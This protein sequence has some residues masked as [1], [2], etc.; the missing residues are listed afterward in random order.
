M[1]S[2]KL[3]ILKGG[4]LTTVQDCGRKGFQSS[5][6]PVAG[7]MDILS[8]QLANIALGNAP[9]AAC[10]EAT[11]DGPEIVFDDPV[12]LC[13][14]GAN[15]LARLNERPVETGRVVFAN[16]NDVLKMG[17]A[18]TGCRAYIAFSGGIDVP[19]VMGSR[20]TFLAGKTG[21]YHGRALKTGDNLT[22]VKT[23]K[24]PGIDALPNGLLHSVFSDKPIRILPGPEIKHFGIDGLLSLLESTFT[25]SPDSNRMGY[26]LD[27]AKV[28]A[29][30]GGAG[31]I[32]SPVP[33]GCIQIPPNG[34]PM[35]LM[36]DRQ[37]TGG[38]PR[39]AIVATI[40]HPRLAQLKPG[41]RLSFEEIR[42]DEAQ[43]LLTERE[44]TIALL[45]NE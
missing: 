9:N 27:G 7:A 3:Q 38:Y 36:A 13:I 4:M 1:T 34:Q 12:H 28:R 8:L 30:S 11:L 26:R 22:L 24:Q 29:E 10:L 44:K 2:R 25:V 23:N 6:M 37:T 42:L 45:Q 21:G 15:M 33:L 19:V 20:S 43:N 14:C 39:M 18:T 16:K 35:I 17:F 40:D 41:D 31:I 32:S 5:G